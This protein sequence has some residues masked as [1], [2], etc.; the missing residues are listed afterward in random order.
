MTLLANVV[1]KLISLIG[2]LFRLLKDICIKVFNI[3]SSCFTKSSIKMMKAPGTAGK[4]LIGRASFESNPS[5]YFRNLRAGKLE[6]VDF[7]LLEPGLLQCSDVWT[8]GL[9][10]I[11]CR[12]FCTVQQADR[13]I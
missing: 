13:A 4:F 1:K 2:G 10:L 8:S 12:M 3:C 11:D 7:Q 6:V 5:A 9:V